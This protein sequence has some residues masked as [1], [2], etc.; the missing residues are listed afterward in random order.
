MR[1]WMV[2]I[3]LLGGIVLSACGSPSPASPSPTP[4]AAPLISTSDTVVADA[5]VV[6]VNWVALGLETG[7]QVIAVNVKEGDAVKAG[8]V[9][10]Q[11]DDVDAKLAVAKAEAE[12]AQAQAQLAKTKAV[13]RPAEIAA[14]EQGV[15]EAEAAVLAAQAQLAQL[16]TAVRPADIAAAEA[17]LAQAAYN[18]KVA[19]DRY[20]QAEKGQREN[21]ADALNVANQDYIAAQKRLDQLKTGPTKNELDAARAGIS[22]A[23]AQQARAQAQLDLLKAGASKEQIAVSEAGVK[24][25]Q[26]ALDAAQAQLDDLQLVAPMDGTVASLDIKVGQIAAP[27]VPVAQIAD[28]SAW[29]IETDDLT[30][31]SVVNVQVGDSAIIVFDAIPDLEMNGKVVRIKEFGEDKRGDIT[32]TVIIQPDQHDERLRWNMTASVTI[33][34]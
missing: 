25:A 22:V 9:L 1:K 24:Q 11:L 33:G 18:K 4:E 28:L 27:G 5:M 15:K 8:D 2:A 21:A 23:Q 34:K 17:G 13:A 10:V 19:Q 3:I 31:L 16:Q 26:A 20:D 30:E 7:G 14:A 6:P 29:Q 32:Y 12:L